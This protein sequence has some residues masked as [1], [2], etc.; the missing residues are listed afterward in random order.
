[1]VLGFADRS[2][3]VQVAKLAGMPQ[4][5]L[6]RAGEVLNKLN[7]RIRKPLVIK[8]GYLHSFHYLKNLLQN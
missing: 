8:T 7:S 5:V 4:A 3:G 6:K 1:V 2:Y